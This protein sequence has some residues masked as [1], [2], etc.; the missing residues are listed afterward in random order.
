MKDLSDFWEWTQS[1]L[2]TFVSSSARGIEVDLSKALVRGESS[3]RPTIQSTTP[4]GT[5]TRVPHGVISLSNEH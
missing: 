5:K 1:K 3:G 2:S 4:R